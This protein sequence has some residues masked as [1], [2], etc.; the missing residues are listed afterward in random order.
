MPLQIALRDLLSIYDEGLWPGGDMSQPSRHQ[1][2]IEI[3]KLVPAHYFGY[4]R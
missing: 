4:R 1:R 2:L 3:R